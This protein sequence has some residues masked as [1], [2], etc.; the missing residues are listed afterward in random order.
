MSDEKEA[1][2][3]EDAETH[4]QDAADKSE[5][6]ALSDDNVVDPSQPDE[7]KEGGLGEKTGALGGGG[8]TEPEGDKP[9]SMQHPHG[10]SG[11]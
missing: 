11:R 5:G 6:G 10:E 8:P 9:E 1:P 3:A 2:G 4:G 7:D